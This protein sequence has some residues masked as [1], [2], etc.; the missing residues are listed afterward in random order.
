MVMVVGIFYPERYNLPTFTPPGGWTFEGYADV[1]DL[2]EDFN[3]TVDDWWIRVY[4][5]VAGASEPANYTY[6]ATIE[7][8]NEIDIAILTY[9][10]APTGEAMPRR[11]S[12]STMSSGWRTPTSAR[13]SPPMRATC[14][15]TSITTEPRLLRRA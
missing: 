7:N 6:G 9:I 12:A 1:D 5:K 8:G 13:P 11:T 3:E 14:C 4:T 10:G 2:D 15:S